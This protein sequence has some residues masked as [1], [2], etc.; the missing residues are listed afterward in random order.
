MSSSR[1]HISIYLHIQSISTH[2]SF[3]CFLPSLSMRRI[4]SHHYQF[5]LNGLNH[6]IPPPTSLWRV[7]H[8]SLIETRPGRCCQDNCVSPGGC[9][10]TAA[11]AD[12]RLFGLISVE[13]GGGGGGWWLWCQEAGGEL[14]ATGILTT[15]K[16]F[17]FSN[18][19]SSLSLC[20]QHQ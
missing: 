14:Q 17:N 1:C 19:D 3:L 6:F 16:S 15:G 2:M 10:G 4:S 5:I 7:L 18:T 20:P 12:S 8:V 11:T 13:G 9:G